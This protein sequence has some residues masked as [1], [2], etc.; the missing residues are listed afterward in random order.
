MKAYPDHQAPPEHKSIVSKEA[1]V[2]K[3]VQQQL[4]HGGSAHLFI[5]LLLIYL[6]LRK[7][8]LKH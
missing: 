1:L 7:K 4:S 2:V 3:G 5:V 8:A 6:H